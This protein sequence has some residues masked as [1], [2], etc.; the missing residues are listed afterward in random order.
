MQRDDDQD[1]IRATVSS[2]AYHHEHPHNGVSDM[3]LKQYTCDVHVVGKG[4]AKGVVVWLK[5]PN[6]VEAKQAA[7][8]Q[9]PGQK[10]SSVVNVKLKK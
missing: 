4:L 9:F 3:S 2:S 8:S 5:A 1:R 7:Q 10:L 6:Q